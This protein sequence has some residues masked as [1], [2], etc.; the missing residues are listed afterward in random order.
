M[1][2]T[3]PRHIANRI[4]QN[5][6][7]LSD[8]IGFRVV[9]RQCQNMQIPREHVC[10]CL[11]LF[12][13]EACSV[14]DDHTDFFRISAGNLAQKVPVHPLVDCARVLLFGL[15]L[16]AAATFGGLVGR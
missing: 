16:E 8:G 9:R 10:I 13:V 15:R 2:E 12:V 6:P 1:P 4:L 14:F 5:V 11:V 7:E 3:F